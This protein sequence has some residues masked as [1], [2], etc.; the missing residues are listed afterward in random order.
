MVDE[1]QGPQ[2]TSERKETTPIPGVVFR[3]GYLGISAGAPEL[4]RRLLADEL[5]KSP[6]GLPAE[7]KVI[8]V[9]CTSTTGKGEI[10]D[11]PKEAKSEQDKDYNYLQW[12]GVGVNKVGREIFPVYA[13]AEGGKMYHLNQK[14]RF[15]L[16]M[17]DFNGNQMVRFMGGAFYRT[18]VWERQMTDKLRKV[19]KGKLRTPAIK[20]TFKLDRAFC[21]DNDLPIPETDDLDDTKG[22]GLKDYVEQH[23]EL[24]KQDLREQLL[25]EKKEAGQPDTALDREADQ[26]YEE[27]ILKAHEVEHYDSAILGQNIRAFRNIFRVADVEEALKDKDDGSRQEKLHAVLDVSRTILGKEKGRELSDREYIA[28]FASLMGE[29]AAILINHDVFHND[30]SAHRQDI[31]LAAEICDPDAVKI[32]DRAFFSDQKNRPRWVKKKKDAKDWREEGTRK[33]H[34]NA[35]TVGGHLRPLIAMAGELQLDLTP[36]HV[37]NSY[38]DSLVMGLSAAKK[39]EMWKRL[40]AFVIDEEA[41]PK[42]VEKLVHDL[43]GRE[44]AKK[45]FAGYELMFAAIIKRSKEKLGEAQ[46]GRGEFGEGR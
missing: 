11:F 13:K 25:A 15:P 3:D 31:T 32:Y 24:I 38:V 26:V 41:G 39:K 16:F 40:A 33:V 7:Q 42:L 23:R 43:G 36:D 29:Q 17:L 30:L 19:T 6:D 28:E 22:T 8:P 1:E 14:A 20:E 5:A 34:S 18:L 35:L 44:D 10:V 46:G 9:F 27:K 4:R 21:Q 45:N 37:I 12:K 2:N